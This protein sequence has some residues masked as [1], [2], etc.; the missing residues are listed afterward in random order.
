MIVIFNTI[1]GVVILSHYLYN[2]VRVYGE[3]GDLWR[4]VRSSLTTLALNAALVAYT[5]RLFALLA[6][7]GLIANV[8]MCVRNNLSYKDLSDAV[9][10]DFR[11]QKSTCSCHK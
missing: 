1:V 10:A 7:I 6:L 5:P 3:G 4:Y 9:V 11:A 8:A 2:G